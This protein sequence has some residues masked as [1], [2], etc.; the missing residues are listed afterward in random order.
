MSA[1]GRGALCVGVAGWLMASCLPKTSLTRRDEVDADLYALTMDMDVA[2]IGLDLP[3][4][5]WHVE[6]TVG[7]SYARTFRDGSMGHLVRLEGMTATVA[8]NGGATQPVPAPFDGAYVELRAFPDGQLLAVAGASRWV[9][10]AGHLEVL[11]VLWPALSPHLPSTRAEAGGPFITS[12]PT[13]VE[14]GPRLRTRLE[15]TWT[16]AG[17][18]WSYAG[19]VRGEGGPVAVSGTAEGRVELGEGDTRIQAHAFDWSRAVTTTWSG[20]RQITQD[21]HIAGSLRHT[22]AAPAPLLDMPSGADDATA[23]ARPLHLRDGRV[24]EDRPVDLASA[25][26][27][28]LLPDDLPPAERAR[29]RAEVAGAGSM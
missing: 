25:L 4:F 16:V 20:G 11:D 27:F 15:T 24:V 5:R 10:D 26:P 12:F 28:L 9:G 2:T 29:L 8:R 18:A 21:Q 1:A 6:G 22:G 23:D 3:P 13:W 17:D 7:V 19:T 14:S